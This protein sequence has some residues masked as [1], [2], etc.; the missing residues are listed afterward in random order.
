[1][2]VKHMSEWLKDKPPGS[3]IVKGVPGSGLDEHEELSF[4]DI[5]LI[6]AGK[7][8]VDPDGEQ[9]ELFGGDE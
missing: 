9:Q 6:H 1:M 5:G 4:A 2:T 8:R 3:L 7:T